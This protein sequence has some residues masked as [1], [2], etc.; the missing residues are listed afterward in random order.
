MTGCH[1]A[2]GFGA[3]LGGQ[4]PEAAAQR[5]DVDPKTDRRLNEGAL[6]PRPIEA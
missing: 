4:A 3:V 6:G 2:I 5:L 1:E